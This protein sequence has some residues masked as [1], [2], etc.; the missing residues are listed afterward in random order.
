MQKRFIHNTNR[1]HY[2][3]KSFVEES[4]I[5]SLH[6]SY[7]DELYKDRM[8]PVIPFNRES[9]LATCTNFSD[10]RVR[11]SF[12]KEYGLNSG[13]YIIEYKYDPLIY[14]IGRTTLFKRRF[15]NHF[16]AD[17]GSKLHLFLNL[18]GWEH[19]NISIV[20]ICTPSKLGSR[21]NFYLQNYLPILNSVFSSSITEVLINKT[22]KSKLEGLKL[23]NYSLSSV[24]TKNRVPLYIYDIDDNGINQYATYFNSIRE[25]SLALNINPTSLS[26]YRDTSIPYRNKLVYSNPIEDFDKVF[27]SSRKNTPQ[28]LLNVLKPVKIWAY[29]A[30]TLKLIEGS[31]F[32]SKTLASSVLGIRRSVIDY[33]LD[34]GKPEGVKGSYLYSRP[35]KETEMKS[36]IDLSENLQ[37]GNKIEVWVYN[38]HTLE[39]INNSPFCSIQD[40]AN[41]FNVNYRTISR[42]LDT[43]LATMQNKILVYFFKKEIDL[44]FKDELVKSKPVVAGY[45]RSEIWVYQQGANGELSLIPDQPFKTKREAIRTLG[46]HIKELNKYLDTSKAYKNFIF[47]T[48]AQK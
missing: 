11:N 26:Q 32:V 43:K 13:I 17:S 18:V 30:K 27:E 37:L 48:N 39:L 36:L 29:D 1:L 24:E 7:I 38:A 6:S 45:N 20:E 9:I 21:E 8:A 19:F 3:N 15:H 46:I 35:I 40:A 4:D 14:Y 28:G 34:K 41:Y 16:K 31:P 23:S 12:L 5:N 10:K 25:A 47:F 42:H 33:F 2:T 44:N 22:L